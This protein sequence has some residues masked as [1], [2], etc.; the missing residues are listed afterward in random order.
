M[1]KIKDK[2]FWYV[3]PYFFSVGIL[4]LWAYWGSFQINVFEYASLSDLAKSSIIPVGSTFFFTLL[5]FMLGEVTYF[6]QFP[7]GGGNETKFSKFIIKR[8]RFFIVMYWLFLTGLCIWQNQAKWLILPFVGMI[9]PSYYLKKTSFLSEFKSE[10]TRLIL[11][12]SFSILPIYSFCAGKINAIKVINGTKCMITES[13]DS[14]Q[15][16]K[17]LGHIGQFDFFSS[18]NNTKIV[19]KKTSNELLVLLKQA[20][21]KPNKSL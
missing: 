18:T 14:E 16:Y 17:F 5:G 9:F 2:Y 3:I 20:E 8:K 21:K 7:P 12:L 4:Y 15:K 19:I 10:S 6:D 13:I 1:E 11:I